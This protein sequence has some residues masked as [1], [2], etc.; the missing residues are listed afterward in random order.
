MYALNKL[1][2]D[3]YVVYLSRVL[4]SIAV[5]LPHAVLTLIL[6]AKGIE[7]YQIGLIQGFFNV[8]MMLVEL[9]SGILTDIFKK[10][11]VF[12]VS[13]VFL[14]VAFSIILLSSNVIM[15]S[16]AWSIYGLASALDTGS[17]E[18]DLINKIKEKDE[19][20]YPQVFQKINQYDTL[21]AIAGSLIGFLLYQIIGVK[22]YLISICML[23]I[24]FFIVVFAYSYEKDFEHEEKIETFKNLMGKAVSQFK[25]SLKEVF[26]KKELILYILGMA[27]LQIYIQFH[28]H[29]WQ[30]M[31]LDRKISE[32]LFYIVYLIFQGI[33]YLVYRIKVTK[34]SGKRI[35]IYLL[36]N[37]VS[38]VFLYYLTNSYIYFLFYCIVVFIFFLIKYYYHYHIYHMVSQN[39]ISTIVSL[40]SSLERLIASVSLFVLSPLLNFI[41]LSSLFIGIIIVV[42][43]L[44]GI[45]FFILKKQKKIFD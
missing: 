14:A 9:P 31:F 10:K 7:I 41:S 33:N 18:S 40:S 13:L 30:A 3:T 26:M 8:T 12:L 17:L 35:G 45:I 19:T 27:L 29:Y 44:M 42:S 2:K 16:I 23:C 15:L 37:M 5:S 32:D 11:N 25:N 39:T 21:G 24:L 1:K 38:G 20:K 34:M 22:I 6:L 36:I 4:T 43:I 28:F